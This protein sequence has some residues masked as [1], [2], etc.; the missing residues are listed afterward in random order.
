MPLR[1]PLRTKLWLA[2]MILSGAELVGCLALIVWTFVPHGP[3][4]PLWILIPIT[5]GLPVVWLPLSLWL[6]ADGRARGVSMNRDP[7][8]SAFAYHKPWVRRLTFFAQVPL[9]AVFVSSL[10][11]F[12]AGSPDNL[13]PERFVASILA[14]F[15]AFGL[16]SSSSAK[17]ASAGVSPI[18][19][20]S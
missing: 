11:A 10:P 14:A 1:N 17:R 15:Y 3:V 5:A 2:L 12:T 8:N 13:G 4:P 16:I 18:P 9:I 20:V 19:V 6:I 7:W